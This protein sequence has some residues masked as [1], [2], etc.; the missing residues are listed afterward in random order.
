MI[1]HL[2]IFYFSMIFND[3]LLFFLWYEGMGFSLLNYFFKINK[4]IMQIKPFKMLWIIYYCFCDL[5]LALN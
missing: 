4:R 3:V 5:M 2:F 1:Y